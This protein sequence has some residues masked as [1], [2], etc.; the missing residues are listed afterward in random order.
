MFTPPQGQDRGERGEM[1]YGKNSHQTERKMEGGGKVPK[2]ERG[3]TQTLG[4][5]KR[6]ASPSE[7]GPLLQ[8]V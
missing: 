5:M 4:N 8:I 7:K 3:E 2:R 6:Y 1:V